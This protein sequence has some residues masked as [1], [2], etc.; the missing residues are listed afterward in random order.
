M[1]EFDRVVEA[2][3]ERLSAEGVDIPKSTTSDLLRKTWE[4]V[5]G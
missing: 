3:N 2:V 5:N 4:G 1:N